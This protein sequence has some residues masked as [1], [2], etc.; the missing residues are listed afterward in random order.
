MENASKALIIAGAILLAILIISLGIL[1]YNQAS[2]TVDEANLDSE[3]LQTFNAKF[4]DYAGSNQSAATVNSLISLINSSN[5]AEASSARGLYVG[6]SCEYVNGSSTTTYTNAAS[7]SN[8]TRSMTS[9]NV[10]CEATARKNL[11]NRV[12]L[13][14]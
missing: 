4:L 8:G 14:G 1:V 9:T 6:L 10:N 2:D 7:Y 3:S 13:C 11:H 12:L 5:S